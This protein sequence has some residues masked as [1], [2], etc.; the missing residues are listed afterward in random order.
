MI[1]QT[2]KP[3]VL[4]PGARP[5]YPPY[6]RPTDDYETPDRAEPS[7]IRPRGREE[8]VHADAYEAVPGKTIPE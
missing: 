2:V 7:R 8:V 3:H 4:H 6:E 1:F 5:A